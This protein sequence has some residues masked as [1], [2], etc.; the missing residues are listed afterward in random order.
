MRLALV[1]AAVAVVAMALAAEAAP[2]QQQGIL[3]YG[4]QCSREIGEI[5][6][7]DCAS[8]TEI[9]VTVDGRR[10]G[11][12]ERPTRCDRPSLLYPRDDK[13]QQCL[14]GA[15]ILDLSRGATQISAYC[16][17]NDPS[18][19]VAARFDE[20]V[21]V[22]HH[23]GNGKTC[24]FASKDPPDPKMGW[25]TSRVP[26]PDEKTPPAA[27]LAAVEFW[28]TPGILAGKNPNCIQ[29]HDAGPFIMSPFIAQVWDK[30]PTDPWGKYSSIGPAFQMERLK[31]MSTPGNTC[32]GCHRIGTKQTCEVFLGL[33]A[34]GHAPGNGP[35]ADRFPLSHWMPTDTNLSEAQWK[36]AHHDSIDALQ[37]CCRDRT[38]PGCTFTPM[39]R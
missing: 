10:I 15:R 33:S 2:P 38:T 35:L 21:I 31:T 30:V 25:D 6:P 20:V 34:G 26:P 8:G 22:L 11:L 4:A 36:A 3:D 23:T 1:I 28:Q 32:V 5:P 16:R 37:A 13:V 12:D 39:P 19:T 18:N 9:P 14:P 27:K 29:C 17:K 7:F 24:W